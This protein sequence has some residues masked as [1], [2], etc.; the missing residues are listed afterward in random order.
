MA[1]TSAPQ[2]CHGLVMRCKLRK[3]GHLEQCPPCSTLA[4]APQNCCLTLLVTSCDG[5]STL[6]WDSHS[7]FGQLQSLESASLY[8]A[9]TC[10]PAYQPLFLPWLKKGLLPL[11]HI[12]SSNI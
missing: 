6:S 8:R 11:P 7:I 12:S 10:L 3:T 4:T 9:E 2:L 1:L 5:K